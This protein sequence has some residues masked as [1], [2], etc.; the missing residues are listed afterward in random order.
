MS[1]DADKTGPVLNQLREAARGGN[2]AR[3]IKLLR[4][5]DAGGRL[6]ADA[7]LHAALRSSIGAG[8][9]AA[10]ITA[11]AE[12]PCPYCKGGRERCRDCE[13]TGALGTGVCRPCAGLGL[14]RCPF[15]NGTSFAGYDMIPRGLRP[16]VMRARLDSAE[17]QIK[18]LSP[19]RERAPESA[20]GLAR[21]VVAIDRCRGVLA[22]AVEQVRLNEAGTVGGT[23]MFSESDLRRTERRC[24]A[25]NAEAEKQIGALLRRLADGF[26]RRAQ[27]PGADA[28]K[29]RLAAHRAK[30]FAGLSTG[31][32]FNDSALRTPGALRVG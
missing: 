8:A 32:G 20:K 4:H 24:R 14:R 19:K 7:S 1:Y 17:R 29:R 31:E 28:E 25:L 27:R 2:V 23:E 30:V 9:A 11:L 3:A 5:A 6:R 21:R 22:N 26:A 13:G 16:A 12:D 10:V 18:A 15:C